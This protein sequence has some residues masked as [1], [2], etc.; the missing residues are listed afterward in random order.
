MFILNDRSGS[1]VNTDYVRE[2][3]LTDTNDS[4]LFSAL[5]HGSEKFTTLERYKTRKE[6]MGARD[7]LARAL[8]DGDTVFHLPESLYYFEERIKKD[9]RTK[10]KGGS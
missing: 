6:A 8:S 5:F 10:R 3:F 2:F 9:A 1:I 7:Q 4:T